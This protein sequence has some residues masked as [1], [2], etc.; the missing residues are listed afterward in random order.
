VSRPT[1]HGVYDYWLGGAQHLRADRELGKAVEERFPSVPVHMR[2]AKKFHLRAARW[3]AEE[4][5]SRFIRAGAVTWQADGNVHDAAREVIPGAEVIYVNRNPEAHAWAQ[6]LLAAD[7]GVTAVRGALSRPAGLLAAGPVAE[8]LAAGEPVCLIIGM[9]LHF[10][11]PA[12]A[13]EITA[14]Y[15]GALPPGSVLVMSLALLDRSPEAD[16]LL[17]MFTPAPLYRHTARDVASWLGDAGL[18]IAPPG[19]TDVRVIP[20]HSWAAS[21]LP[22]RAPGVTVGALGV[23]P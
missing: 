11:P 20:G 8:M 19:V 7:P 23:V 9:A 6:A 15:A 2:A 1:V 16:R 14:A 4:G 10:T 21:E 18:E 17:A 22:P 3:A 5:I 12:K 13:R